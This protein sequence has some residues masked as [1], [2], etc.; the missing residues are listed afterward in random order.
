VIPLSCI[1][2]A[3]SVIRPSCFILRGQ[4]YNPL[5][6]SNLPL[7]SAFFISHLP[8]LVGAKT[9]PVPATRELFQIRSDTGASYKVSGQIEHVYY[10][11]TSLIGVVEKGGNLIKHIIVVST[12]RR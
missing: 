9:P 5:I 4:S 2:T 8:L 6:R 12:A 10:Y 7:V 3:P 11:D 1:N